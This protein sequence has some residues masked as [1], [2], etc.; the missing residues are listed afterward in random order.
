MPPSFMLAFKVP[1][2]ARVFMKILLISKISSSAILMSLIV[3]L[4]PFMVRC[5][6][7]YFLVDNFYMSGGG[8]IH[9]D[10]LVYFLCA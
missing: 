6:I 1:V 8:I 3:R 5:L 4:T 10:R 9:E 2:S 7:S